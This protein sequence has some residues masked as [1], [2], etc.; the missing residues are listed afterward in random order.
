MSLLDE[1]FTLDIDANIKYTP[2]DTNKIN[3]AII[4][5]GTDVTKNIT[6]KMLVNL[7]GV[8]HKDNILNNTDIHKKCK[9]EILKHL[10][11]CKGFSIE[12]IYCEVVTPNWFDDYWICENNHK[13]YNKQQ[14]KY[15]EKLFNKGISSYDI[16]MNIYAELMKEYLKGYKS[17]YILQEKDI[18]KIKNRMR[19]I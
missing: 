9:S 18:F 1:L 11:K 16:C 6:K 4:K 10:E 15:V 12:E 2:I 8:T 5:T 17:D 13:K 14:L 19:G 7:K 3:K